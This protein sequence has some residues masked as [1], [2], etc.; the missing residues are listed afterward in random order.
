ME[1]PTWSSGKES[2]YQCCRHKTRGFN[3]CWRDDILEEEMTTHSSILSW[4]IPWTEE[5]DALQSV[6]W[7]MSW[8]R[9]STHVPVLTLSI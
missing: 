8:T 5:P 9:L 2:T 3:P 4:K 6:G 7:P 1:L